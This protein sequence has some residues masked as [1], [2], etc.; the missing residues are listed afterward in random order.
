MLCNPDKIRQGIRLRHV[1]NNP[2]MANARAIWRRLNVNLN[3]QRVLRK[4]DGVL[5]QQPEAITIKTLMM[6]LIIM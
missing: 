5:F 4:S 3:A 6:I 1:F 2:E